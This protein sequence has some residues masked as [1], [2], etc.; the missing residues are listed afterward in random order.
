MEDISENANQRT[1]GNRKDYYRLNDGSDEEV[2]PSQR[3]SI[4][5]V[6]TST[7]PFSIESTKLI[8]NDD[9]GPTKVSC[10][11]QDSEMN[12]IASN[13]SEIGEPR[14][15]GQRKGG[16][17]NFFTL[18][19]LKGKTFKDHKGRERTDYKIICNRP[20]C[21]T[22]WHTT[23]QKRNNSAGNMLRHLKIA[24]NITN[25]KVSADTSTE[26]ASSLIGNWLSSSQS[27]PIDYNLSLEN[28]I[29]EWVIED[30]QPFTVIENK[31]FQKIFKDL[32]NITLPF[33]AAS[34]LRSRIF[35]RFANFREQLKYLI[36]NTCSKISLSL[37]AW[38]SKNS[39]GILAIIGHWTTPDFEYVDKVLE[40]T[41][42][43][44]TI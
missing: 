32:P 24:H 39:L 29:I 37:D 4:S 3:L 14:K 17:W 11:P 18:K 19:E 30:V 25:V 31:A 5:Q 22:R 36:D 41:E 42:L 1:R 9:V 43:N 33:S 20:L 10:T 23:D 35:D 13:A 38:T 40:F 26:V 34:T 6:S 28:N 27:L 44:G 15:I 7:L 12:V 16:I 2:E 21:P 8:T